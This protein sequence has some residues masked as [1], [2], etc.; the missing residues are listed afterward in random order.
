MFAVHAP[1]SQTAFEW[2]WF[3]KLGDTLVLRA[4]PRITYASPEWLASLP[5]AIFVLAVLTTGLPIVLGSYLFLHRKAL[6]SVVA[7]SRFGWM[8]DRYSPGVEW[9]GLHELLRKCLL[10]G[11]LIYIDAIEMRIA[12]ALLI[13]IVAILNLNYWS[14]FRNVVVFWVSQV[15]FCMT[16]LKY[17]I[18]MFRLTIVQRGSANTYGDLGTFL[19]AIEL[20]TFSLFVVGA[21]LC[22]FHVVTEMKKN[23]GADEDEEGPDRRRS[24]RHGRRRSVAS[25]SNGKIYPYS[26]E[27]AMSVRRGVEREKPS[28][29]R[30]SLILINLGGGGGSNKTRMNHMHSRIAD[31]I[32]EEAETNRALAQ[33]HVEQ[34]R[35]EAAQRLKKRIER[36]K[37]IHVSSGKKEGVGG[38]GRSHAVGESQKREDPQSKLPLTSGKRSRLPPPA[39]KANK[40]RLNFGF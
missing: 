6:D 28:D 8:Y 5:L 17:V 20:I 19:I 10:T 12:C 18:A 1:V 38:V 4:D 21:V 27:L 11:F 13:S 14:P 9:W 35:M 34:K 7:L 22:V 32:M 37:T 23:D 30:R 16:T 26:A 25:T 3:V 39:S 33:S 29:K 15:A 2:F 36:Q 24:K 40:D 31:Q